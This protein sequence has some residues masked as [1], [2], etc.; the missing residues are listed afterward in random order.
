M[1]NASWILPVHPERDRDDGALDAA[2]QSILD[3]PPQTPTGE[4]FLNLPQGLPA[5]RLSAWGFRRE[6]SVYLYVLT[7]AG[8]HRFFHYAAARYGELDALSARRRGRR[9]AANP[10]DSAEVD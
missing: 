1:L 7:R 8:L 5:A 3:Q 9:R 4:R 10:D 6:A 2:L